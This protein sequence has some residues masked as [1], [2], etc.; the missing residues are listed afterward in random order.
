M[1]LKG[2]VC[3][4][5]CRFPGEPF[6][7][8]N[9][10]GFYLSNVNKPRSLLIECSASFDS[11]GHLS[12]LELGR[13][14]RGQGFPELMSLSNVVDGL[15]HG[16]LGQPNS[17]SADMETGVIKEHHELVEPSAGFSD[18]IPS[19]NPDV[20]ERDLGSIRS[21]NAEFVFQLVSLKSLSVRLS[22]DH[23]E[24]AMP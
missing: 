7:H 4:T 11:S 20:T 8:G 22:S 15:L 21:P 1:E 13:L 16:S 12:D 24:S 3:H 5:D 18:E 23:A 14:K 17:L 19:R 9:E 10:V 2:L 6:G